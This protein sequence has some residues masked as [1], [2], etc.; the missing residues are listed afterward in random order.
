[1][2]AYQ[3]LIRGV[4]DRERI[5]VIVPGGRFDGIR[6][7]GHRRSGVPTSDHSLPL[8]VREIGIWLSICLS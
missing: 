7:A 4:N 8:T 2:D 3:N 1:M 6:G 5:K